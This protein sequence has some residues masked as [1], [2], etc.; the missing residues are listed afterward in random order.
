MF[1]LL[2]ALVKYTIGVSQV[3]ENIRDVEKVKPGNTEELGAKKVEELGCGTL[4]VEFGPDMR[5]RERCVYY[6]FNVV[7]EIDFLQHANQVTSVNPSKG[8]S[9]KRYF[10]NFNVI[11]G[12][13][14][15]KSEQFMEKPIGTKSDTIECFESRILSS[16][17]H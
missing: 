2:E 6:R 10:G 7:E 3:F 4:C 14:L 5:G 1:E 16:N 15:Q 9:H 8:V 13:L 17:M 12:Q 11:L